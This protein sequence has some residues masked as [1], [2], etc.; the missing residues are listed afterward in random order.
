MSVYGFINIE[1]TKGGRDMR[2]IRFISVVTVFASIALIG[3]I[4]AGP[5]AGKEVSGKEALSET[6]GC[7]SVIQT[8]S[9]TKTLRL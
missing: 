2:T 1:R 7:F 5:P 3:M 9:A 8:G 6:D 4:L